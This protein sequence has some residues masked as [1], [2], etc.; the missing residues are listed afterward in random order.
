MWF[1]LF[2][3]VSVC[4]ANYYFIWFKR[5]CVISIRIMFLR[6]N[7]E[8]ARIK[9]MQKL[10]EVIEEKNTHTKLLFRLVNLLLHYFQTESV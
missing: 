8:T 6:V 10:K 5:K 4:F 3:N 9:K 7:T 1:F 2:E